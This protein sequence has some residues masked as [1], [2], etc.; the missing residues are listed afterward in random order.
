MEK[1]SR[2]EEEEG[3]E[4]GGGG[5]GGKEG[6]MGEEEEGGGREGKKEEEEEEEE[7]EKKKKKAS[8]K[9]QTKGQQKTRKAGPGL[10]RNSPAVQSASLT[11]PK[12]FITGRLLMARCHMAGDHSV[13]IALVTG[14]PRFIPLPIRGPINKSTTEARVV[15]GSVW[16][17]LQ[18]S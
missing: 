8:T 12:P 16:E 10:E 14:P 9:A 6:E 17:V 5:E 1:S 3:G 11:S 4:G 7:E 13:I 15:Q 2:Q 18:Q